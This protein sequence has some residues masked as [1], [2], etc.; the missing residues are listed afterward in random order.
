LRIVSLLDT[1]IASMNKGDGIIMDSIEREIHDLVKDDF[2]INFP[3]HL[4]AFPRL[5]SFRWGR[6]RIA[7]R[8][9]I[10]I[11]CGTDLFWP[12]M[13]ARP[14]TLWNISLWNYKPFAGSVFCGV[15][16]TSK[17]GQSEKMTWY[18]R[19]LWKKIL[20]EDLVH[21]VRDEKTK[22]ALEDM[23]L[24][25]VNTGCPTMWMLT[26]E[27]C[28]S[29]PV[30]KADAA[31]TALSDK[32]NRAS[33]QALIDLLLEKYDKVFLWLQGHKDIKYLGTLKN[34]D[35]LTIIPPSVEA[36]RKVLSENVLDYIGPRLHAGVFAMQHRRRSVI[37]G[38]DHRASHFAT[39]FN[40]PYLPRTGIDGI[41][42]WIDSEQVTDVRMDYEAIDLWKSQLARKA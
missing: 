17:P 1:S 32:K 18:S 35:K 39:E 6:A 10:K 16:M 27:F 21:S 8:S 2:V 12:N 36:Y 24:R 15:G 22:N 13:L 41:R 33:D 4:V 40:I 25:A 20:S 30:K 19:I 3:T 5:K 7:K 37:L 34:S 23:G 42:N 29:I 26:P 9:D 28:A 14:N 11:V 31:V 38:V